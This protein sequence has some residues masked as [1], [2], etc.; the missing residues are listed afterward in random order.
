M[1][2]VAG[3]VHSVDRS[4]S[5]ANVQFSNKSPWCLPLTQVGSCAV[6]HHCA[7]SSLCE[8]YW[9]RPS[10]PLCN[11]TA[12]VQTG[13]TRHSHTCLPEV[14]I[15]MRRAV[16]FVAVCIEVAPDDSTCHTSDIELELRRHF[17]EFSLL[18]NSSFT[19]AQIFSDRR[20]MRFMWFQ[21][22]SLLLQSLSTY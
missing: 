9:A 17:A 10:G 14:L 11:P 4:Q 6:C 18:W 1:K 8:R 2:L 22:I 15:N 3:R 13:K 20:Q 12:S 5:R 19:L 16:C 21:R 7:G